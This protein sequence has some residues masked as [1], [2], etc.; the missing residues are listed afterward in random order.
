MESNERPS[1]EIGDL[2]MKSD[3][4]K[5]GNQ[6]PNGLMSPRMAVAGAVAAVVGLSLIGYNMVDRLTDRPK[7]TPRPAQVEAQWYVRVQMQDG[8]VSSFPEASEAACR[9][10]A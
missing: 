7:F 1:P 3:K 2:K 5:R 6:K 9:G 8:S 4:L 10:K